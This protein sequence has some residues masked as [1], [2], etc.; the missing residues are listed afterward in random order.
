MTLAD[1]LRTKIV[2]ALDSVPVAD[3][4]DVYVVSLYV[5]DAEDDPRRPTITVGYNTERQA[6][7]CT[8]SASDAPEA[9][10]NYA[11]W[12]QNGLTVVCDDDSD[13]AGAALR[14]AWAEARGYWYSDEE[15]ERDFYAV[16]QRVEPLTGEFVRIAVEVVQDVHRDGVIGRIFGRPIPVVI[17]ELEYY[18][19]IAH[20]NEAAN[21]PG[22]ADAFAR[23][24]RST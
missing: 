5:S 1:H 2:D 21:P 13:Q 22:L 4:T 14:N 19:E 17:H 23:W 6:A 15:K 16:L 9:R 20:Q 7:D 11:F 18:E 12:L 3:R 8:P 24:V 10:W